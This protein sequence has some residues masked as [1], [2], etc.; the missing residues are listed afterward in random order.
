MLSFTSNPTVVPGEKDF[1]MG[2]SRREGRKEGEGW[3][4]EG[5]RERTEDREEKRI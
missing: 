4:R 2:G 3:E 1:G 5:E